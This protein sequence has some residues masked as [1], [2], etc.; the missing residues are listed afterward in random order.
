MTA[1]ALQAEWEDAVMPNTPRRS[2]RWLHVVSHTDPRY[3]GLSAAVPSL[4]ARLS[5]QQGI[6]ATLA[7]FC[8]P[9]E[10]HRPAELGAGQISFWPLSRLSWLLGRPLKRSFAATVAEVDG[11]HIHGLWEQST[12]AACR[13][14]R[15]LGK[16]YLLSAH[17]MLE[18][19]ALASRR[20]KK[21]IYAALVERRN[22][23]GAGCLHALTPAEA[24]QYRNFGARGPIAV[25]PNAVDLPEEI[26]GELF[27]DRFPDLRGKRLVLFLSRLHPK[28]GLDLL[29]ASWAEVACLHPEAR[30]VIAGPDSDG[31][32]AS[33]RQQAVELG[34]DGQVTFPGMLTGAVKW[35]ALDAAEGFVLPSY[36]EGLSMALLE[37]LGVGVPVIATRN[38][39]MPEITTSDA[40]WEIEATVPALVTALKALLSSAP[41]GNW[42]KGRN[43]VRLV[44]E[45]Y[46]PA[47]VARQMAA[48]Y[49]FVLGGPAPETVQQLPGGAR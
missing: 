6:D 9:G 23:A 33:L 16:P 49:E 27:L 21:Q 43:G 18:P 45:R 38:C 32:Q 46:T 26:H 30:L 14:A 42:T 37:A 48:V 47:A 15:R 10:E 39:N 11:L 7:A 5:G 28:K 22:V 17:G 4:A 20:R 35:S 3:G 44:A 36:S 1:P 31:L 34:I 29:M 41:E 13:L 19:W 25:V 12:A 40:G 24:V 8:L 2:R